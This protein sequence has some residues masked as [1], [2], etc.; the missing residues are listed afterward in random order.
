[1]KFIIVAVI[2]AFLMGC[3]SMPEGFEP[4][5]EA[6]ASVLVACPVLKETTVSAEQYNACR[7]AV[8]DQFEKPAK[9]PTFHALPMFRP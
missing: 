1:M 5:K 6:P 2:S 9:A 4:A 8:M 3:S 7:A